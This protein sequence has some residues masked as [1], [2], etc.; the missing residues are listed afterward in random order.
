MRNRDKT[1]FK[2]TNNERHWK[3][4]QECKKKTVSFRSALCLGVPNGNGWETIFTQT[5][6]FLFKCRQNREMAFGTA[7]TTA[8]TIQ[9]Y[10]GG[11][12]VRLCI[13]SASHHVSVFLLLRARYILWPIVSPGHSAGEHVRAGEDAILYF[14]F[15]TIWYVHSLHISSLL[16]RLICLYL[17]QK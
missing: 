2:C 9:M 4:S 13:L 14:L 7:S 10:H 12:S 6:Y 17:L 5:G 11:C 8:A 15:L 1:T 3:E 16:A